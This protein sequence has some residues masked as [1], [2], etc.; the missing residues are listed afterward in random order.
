MPPS[1]LYNVGGTWYARFSAKGRLIRAS[2]RTGDLREART[3]LKALKLK[4]ERHGYGIKDPSVWEDA[5]VAYS[6]GVLNAGGVKPATAQRYRVS[7]R[8][9]SDHMAG[10]PLSAI[11]QPMLSA[12]VAARQKTGATNATIRRDLT[13]VSRVLAFAAAQGLGGLQANVADAVDRKLF[14]ETRKPIRAPGAADIDRGVQACIDAGSPGLAALIEFL[15]ATGL[16]S[17]EALRARWEDISAG[18]LTIHETKTSRPR[19]IDLDPACLPPAPA[20]PTG[21]LFATLP[22]TS[23][24]L[25]SAWQYIRAR[26]PE[27]MQFRLHD[28]RHAYAIDQIRRGRDIYDLS[29]HLGH[30]SVKTTEI[31]LGY[32]AGHRA[33]ER[34]QRNASAE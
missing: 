15:R 7:L 8:M 1:N 30:T 28:L 31:Y 27:I 2:L 24:E 19:T 33:V 13:A 17:G 4:A 23:G 14:R 10:T 18:E 6:D 21:R 11:D 16:R 12:L 25:S 9:V 5:V 20:H 32:A 26:R 3:R 22:L 34:R 29:R